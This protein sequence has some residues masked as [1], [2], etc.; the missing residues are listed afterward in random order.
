[1][2]SAA[3]D[4]K[5]GSRSRAEVRLVNERLLRRG[6]IHFMFR[7]MILATVVFVIPTEAP[8]QALSVLHIKVVL[9]DADQK[10]T[11]VPRHA[12][13]ISDNPPTAVPRRIVTKVD[14]TVDVSL[15]PG[16]YTIESDEPIAF[17]GKTYGWTQTVDIVAG[18]DAVLELTADNAEV[19]AA[20]APTS[21]AAPLE[22]DPAFL[23]PEWQDSVVALWT[24]DTR[25]SG[26]VFDA[27][28]LVATSQRVVGTATSV[29]VQLTT[30]LKV[31]GR[32]LAADAARDVAVVWI[33]PTVAGS[34]KPVPLGCT[35][36]PKPSI[37]DRQDIFTIGSPFREQKGLRAGTVKRVEAQAMES[38]LLLASGSAGGPV[39]T[40]AGAV[41]GLTS[42][43][44][45]KDSRRN[46]E[47]RVIRIDAVCEVVA[48][49]EKKM[50]GATPPAGTPLP[51]E[52]VRPFPI[53]ALKN[54]GQRRIASL[55]AYQM[56]SSEFEVTF[57]TPLQ[58]YSAHQQLEQSRGRDTRSSTRA[59]TAAE[60]ALRLLSEFSNWSAYV[61]EFPPVLL[62][63]VTPKFVEGFW[64]TVA[65]GA[66]RTQGVA[67][68]PIKHFKSGFSRLRALCG[69]AEVT[70]IHP[71]TMEQRISE[72]DAIHEGLYVF[73]P[74]AIG[75][76]C[77]SVTL[78]LYSEKEPE[79]AD[80]RVVDPKLLQQVWQDFAPYRAMKE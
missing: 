22:A 41:I 35:Q 77:G 54:A 57:I 40:A 56:T 19:V 30:A 76:Q 3:G 62:V 27:K 34:V 20:R 7:A 21:G 9:V 46:G 42:L 59:P 14:G 58:T 16:N 67:L 65:R 29:E 26:F 70:P 36:T 25:A 66:A 23:L 69:E 31:T 44:D 53:E 64:T 47:S 60:T 37:L 80:P 6:S 61:G 52:P 33:D 78:V 55:S 72:S 1:M 24:A 73:E 5:F 4:E 75:P 74:G 15:R 48:V 71:F 39:F 2:Q 50:N 32:V 10:V 12:L 8:G 38:D 63:R 17:R 68:P 18:R 45:E 28:G 43:V 49:A 11:P 51:V 79:K 13:L